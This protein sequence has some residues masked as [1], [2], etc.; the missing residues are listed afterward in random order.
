M[1]ETACIG[2][3]A[4]IFTHPLQPNPLQKMNIFGKLTTVQ[5]KIFIAFADNRLENCRIAEMFF[6]KLHFMQPLGLT[7]ALLYNKVLFLFFGADRDAN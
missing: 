1:S 3:A 6:V 4:K 2:N 7:Y 5:K